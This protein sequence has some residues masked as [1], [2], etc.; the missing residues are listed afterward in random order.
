MVDGSPMSVQEAADVLGVD[1]RTVRLLAAR[2]DLKGE[3]RGGSWW[4]DRGAVEQRRRQ[5]PGRGRPLSAPLAW[6]I[7]L[8]ASGLPDPV[9]LAAHAHSSERARTWLETHQLAE[10]AVRLRARGRREDF[11]AHQSELRRILADDSVMLTGISAS[12]AVGISGGGGAIEGYAPAGDRDRLVSEHALVP[13]EGRVLLRWVDDDIWPVV[14]ADVAP[15]AVVLVDLL[16]H[17]DPRAR[18]EARR[19]LAP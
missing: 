10:G 9:E 17:D 11:D 19:L 14:R 15:R 1:P 16:E 7:L 3:K 6:S 4:L 5:R 18:R 13:G 12:Q 2:G 8:R